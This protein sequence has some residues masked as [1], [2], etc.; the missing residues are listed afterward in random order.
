MRRQ[1]PSS[2]LTRWKNN[3]GSR[4]VRGDIYF[5][6]GG[7]RRIRVTWGKSHRLAKLHR[8]GQ[9]K[10]NSWELVNIQYDCWCVTKWWWRRWWCSLFQVTLA[11]DKQRRRNAPS[12]KF[13]YE[14]H[15][16]ESGQP[17]VL[18]GP[19]QMEHKNKSRSIWYTNLKIRESSS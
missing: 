13:T 16:Q 9:W 19:I 14:V 12:C 18:M 17:L 7:R 4:G 3:T 2:R 6:G 5:W 1:K 10:S 15:N 11:Q 8:I